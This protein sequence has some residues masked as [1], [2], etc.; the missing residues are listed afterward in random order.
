[1]CM[2]L[3]VCVYSCTYNPGP[4]WKSTH[5]DSALLF[6]YLSIVAVYSIRAMFSAYVIVCVPR[7]AHA[8]VYVHVCYVCMFNS[9]V[10]KSSKGIRRCVKGICAV[11]RIIKGICRIASKDN[12]GIAVLRINEIGS[13]G[14]VSHS[15]TATVPPPLHGGRARTKWRSGYIRL[16]K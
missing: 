16:V 6:I 11:V 13:R 1:M 10:C 4:P 7:S 5:V 2:Y 12:P 3:C 14:E 9:L 8:C 15:Q